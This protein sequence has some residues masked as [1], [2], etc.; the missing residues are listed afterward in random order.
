MD[1]TGLVQLLVSEI[2]R[3]GFAWQ[4]WILSAA[5]IAPTI[6]LVPA[7]GLRGVVAPVRVF[8]TL[9][10]GA[11]V[12][13]GL[14]THGQT[15][16][17]A[18]ALVSAVVQGIPVAIAAAIPLWAATMV[19][20]IIDALRGSNDT[21]SMPVVEGQ[22]TTIGVLLALIASTFFLVSGGPAR[23]VGALA[24]PKL[25]GISA[26][27]RA[28]F[29]IA[30]GVQ[31]AVSIAGPMLAAAVIVEVSAALVAKSAAPSQIHFL[32]APLRSFAVLAIASL[33]LN[34]M[35]DLVAIWVTTAPK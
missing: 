19:G 31:I 32:L 26:W 24:A 23:V 2:E 1:S 25:E 3:S 29:D 7:F 27:I 10:L 35:M 11:C 8:M 21:V 9:C 4:G 28:G 12:A 5:R 13:P 20:G 17:I 15:T 16:S 33:M 6:V 18:F 30:A 14:W 34:R 22:P